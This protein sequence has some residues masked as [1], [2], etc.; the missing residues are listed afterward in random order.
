MSIEQE[1]YRRSESACELCGA[2][3][4]LDILEVTP[5]N[6]S[7]DQCILTCNRCREQIEKTD[8]DTNHWRCLNDSMW[9]QIP[10]VQVMVWR[11]LNQLRSEGWPQD[12]LDMMYLE[13][14]VRTWAEA[15]ISNSDAIK[16]VD[17]NGAQLNAGNTVSLIKDLDIK[18]S[19]IT[20]K[21]G[22]AVRNI[23]LVQDNPGQIEGRID[24]Q[25]IIIL[26]KFV[27]KQG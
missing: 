27:K 26:T 17:C 20:A 8:M 1:L 15:D 7:A 6:G 9:S 11:I 23:R 21:R 3:E 14:E 24:G 5:S 13:D 22:T 12:L 10:A 19:S 2:A 4:N 25:M 16:H 18:R